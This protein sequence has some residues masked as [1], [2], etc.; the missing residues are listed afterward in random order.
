MIKQEMETLLNDQFHREMFSAMQY[1]AVTSWFEDQNLDGF[2]HFFRIQ[3]QEEMSHAMKQF[4]YLHTVGGKITMKA[5][6]QPRAEFSS[7]EEVFEFALEQ[8]T[9]VTDSIN[10]LMKRA[11]DFGDFATQ[12]FLQWFVTEQ[13]EEEDMVRKM[14]HKVKLI[15]DN[16]SALFHLNEELLKRQPEPEADGQGI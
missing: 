4:D 3:A 14:L 12:T 2:A 8:E 13:V 15:G 16:T 11:V 1:L 7:N 9:G 10:N 6:S 5:I